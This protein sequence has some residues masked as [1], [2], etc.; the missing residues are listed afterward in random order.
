MNR[1]RIILPLLFV[2]TLFVVAPLS[3][4]ASE[5]VEAAFVIPDGEWTVGD[6]IALTLEI[7]HPVGYH[8]ITPELDEAWGALNIQ[9]QSAPVTIANSA[10]TETTSIQ[11]DARIFTPGTFSTPAL[12]LSLTDGAGN[13]DEIAVV[14]AT[15]DIASVLVEGDA[16][17]RDIKPQ[18]EMSLTALWPYILG[19]LVAAFALI[20]ALVLWL[21]KRK[22][23]TIDNRLAHERAF[24]ELDRITGLQLPPQGR[25]K[26]HYT[27]VSA[28]I[29]T[30]MEATYQV[31]VVERTTGEIRTSF[32]EKDISEDVAKLFLDFLNKSDIVKFSTFTPDVDSAHHLL[33]QANALIE[34]TKPEPEPQQTPEDTTS[35]PTLFSK[36]P[37]EVRA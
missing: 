17:L 25:F 4:I 14:P 27:L 24:D 8:V 23:E 29:R 22:R 34:R 13:L 3:V 20:A 31:P 37:A 1:L 30:Y 10:G 2:I 19:G 33:A 12:T 21:R 6:P 9:E 18:F 28:C 36:R 35:G 7:N 32:K 26:E 5:P 16:E 15:L 11:F